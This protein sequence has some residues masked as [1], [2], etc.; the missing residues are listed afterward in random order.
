MVLSEAGKASQS[1]NYQS[2]HWFTTQPNWDKLLIVFS[3]SLILGPL[4]LFRVINDTQLKDYV[5]PRSHM[6]SVWPYD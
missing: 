5:F 6:T 4:V 1:A 2:Q 3:S